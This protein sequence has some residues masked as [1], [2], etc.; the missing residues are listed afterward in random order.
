MATQP[1][2]WWQHAWRIHGFRL[3]LDTFYQMQILFCSNMP[4][5]LHQLR[6][7]AAMWHHQPS[8]TPRYYAALSY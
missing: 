3:K 1:S 8:Y 6:L 5:L 2:I 7:T 4:R